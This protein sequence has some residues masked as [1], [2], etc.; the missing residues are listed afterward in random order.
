MNNI[1]VT[2]ICPIRNEEKFIGDCIESLVNQ[3]FPL[4]KSEIL[5]IDGMSDDR[6]REIVQSYSAKFPQVKLLDNPGR[7][8]PMAMNIGIRAARGK[9]I[10]RIDGHAKADANFVQANVD[11]LSAGKAECVGGPIISVNASETGKAIAAAMSSSFG[12]GNSRFRTTQDQECFVDTVA[13]PGFTRK[14]FEKVGL[15]DEELVRCQDDEL[16]FRIRSHGGQILLTPTIKSWYY[17]RSSLKK[18]WRQ[19]FGYG[20]WKIRVF[21]KHPGKMQ[22]RHFIPATFVAGLL[23]LAIA[24][25]AFWPAHALLGGILALYFGG[26]LMAAFRIKASQPEL[27]LWKLLVSFYILHFSYGFGFIKGLIQFLPNWFKKRAENPAVLLPA[28]PSSNR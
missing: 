16:N 14:L 24:G 28:E 25:F 27:P 18:L 22:L 23:T 2:V 8:V 26:S 9:Y 15:F 10:V 20:F 17:P 3:T 21:Q 4:E 11:A 1:E 12:V 7:I 6:T 19:Y 13:F 5:I